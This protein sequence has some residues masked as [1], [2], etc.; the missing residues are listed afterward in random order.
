MRPKLE[1]PRPR[2]FVLLALL[3]LACLAAWY[4]R[5][6]HPGLRPGLP[7]GGEGLMKQLLAI[8]ARED[9]VDQTVWAKEWLAE[10]CGHVFERLWDAVNATTNKLETI[11]QFSVGSIAFP[12]FQPA[13]PIGHGIQLYAPASAGEANTSQPGADLPPAAWREWLGA[14]AR[15]GWQLDQL[16][17]RHNRF[18]LDASGRPSRS[19][20][21]FRA[22]VTRAAPETRA[23]LEGDLVVDWAPATGADDPPTVR[24]VD[25]QRLTLTTRAGPPAF[26]EVLLDVVQPPEKSHF[27]D[28]LILHDLDGDGRPEIILAARNRVYQLG[29]DGRFQARDLCRHWPGL[30]FTAVVADF[31]GDGIDD[32]LFARFEGLF[33]IR[34]APGGQFNAPPEAVWAAPER[35]RYGQALTCGDVDG[36]GDGDLDVWFGQYKN[37]YDGGQMPTPYY[38][39]NDGNPS[40]LLLNVGHGQFTDATEAA[41]LAKHRWRRTYAASLVDLDDDGDLDLLKVSDFAGVEMY[42]NDGRGHF[43]DVTAQCLTDPKGFGMAHALADF[44]VDG[45]LDLFVTGMHCPTAL[46]LIHLGLSRPAHPDYLAMAPPMTAGNKL[47]LA[48]PDGRFEEV[49]PQAGVAH[50]GWSWGCVAADFDNDGWPDLAIA[51]GHETRQSVQDYD[52]EFWLH[53]IYL[54]DS[55]EDRVKAIYFASKINQTRGQGM[56]YGGYEQ[57]RLFLNRG[58]R[59]FTDVAHLFGVALETDS[60]NLAAADL[61]G[62]GRQDLIV[63][64]FEVWPEERQTLR[65]YKNEMPDAGNWIAVHLRGATGVSPLG[66]KVTLRL[67]GGRST[68]RQIVTG[69]SHRSQQANTAHFGLGAASEVEAVEVR[70]PDG[71]QSHLVRPAANRV[72]DITPPAK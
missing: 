67:T 71:R 27:I 58:G 49:A 66:A 12:Q 18:D 46:R 5:R 68:V 2:L 39:A 23:A 45:R 51:N 37:P 17:F 8:Q 10:R 53:D 29:A 25:A 13:E 7:P 56:S 62:D 3:A 24:H 43:T 48:Q 28:P 34:G 47:L 57:N 35:V 33:L 19:V 69:D 26:R 54:A 72:H 38:D 64:T 36:D 11:A 15:E 9:Q 61:D 65:V 4:W 1:R 6:P 21:A 59:A 22:L 60:R 14:R 70:W 52:P 31:D 44:D 20:F 32:F 41:G 55:K 30:I 42:A 16:E 63:T 40:Y 50:S